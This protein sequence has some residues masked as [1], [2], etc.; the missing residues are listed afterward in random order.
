MRGKRGRFSLL[1]IVPLL[2]LKN[3]KNEVIKN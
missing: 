3:W 2:L 1:I